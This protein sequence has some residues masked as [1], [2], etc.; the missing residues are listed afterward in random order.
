MI[1]HAK[2]QF[3]KEISNMA[4]TE[5]DIAILEQKFEAILDRGFEKHVKNCP[6]AVR[7]KLV[8]FVFVAAILGSSL[9]N[10]GGEAIA[11]FITIL[12]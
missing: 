4:L 9:G 5:V 11:K 8:A 12:F 3:Y 10:G 7:W 2:K 1:N 6:H